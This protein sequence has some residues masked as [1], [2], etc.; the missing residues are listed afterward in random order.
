MTQVNVDQAAAQLS[1]LL[2]RARDGEE[3]VIA[4]HG[5]PLAKLVPV[6]TARATRQPGSAI[7]KLKIH[8]SF[9]DP[10]PNDLQQAF[11]GETEG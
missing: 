11:E 3:I 4:D 6:R 7:G 5:R 10:L 9:F 8:D 2:A 1:S